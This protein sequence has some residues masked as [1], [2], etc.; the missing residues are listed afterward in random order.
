[1]E[2]MEEPPD[3]LDASCGD[4]YKT[5]MDKTVRANKDA[6]VLSLLEEAPMCGYDL[7]KA[8]FMRYGVFLSQ[9]LIYPIL[10]TLE[11]EGMLKSGFA[12]GSMRT[13][14]YIITPQGLALAKRKREAL[15]QAMEDVILCIKGESHV[16]GD[17]KRL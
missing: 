9:G 17:H 4:E 7:I 13:K 16:Q 6:I 10:Y 14:E 11:E 1:M 2:A 12:K 8:I 15:V 3:C 5:S